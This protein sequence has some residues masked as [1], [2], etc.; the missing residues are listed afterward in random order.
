MILHSNGQV[1]QS[2]EQAPV[3]SEAVGSIVNSDEELICWAVCIFAFL[4]DWCGYAQ[5]AA[6]SAE[7]NDTMTMSSNDFAEDN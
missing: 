3:T 4:E 6:Q 2:S 5:T 7:N 1:A